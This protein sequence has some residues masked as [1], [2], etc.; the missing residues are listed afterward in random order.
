MAATV[1]RAAAAPHSLAASGWSLAVR[2]LRFWLTNYRRTWRGSIYSS[3]LN[4]LL[5]LGAM[6]LGL[7]SL[8]DAHGTAPLGRVTYLAFLAPGLLAAAAMETAVGE[9]TYPVYGSVKWNKTYQAAVASP[10]RPE[11]IF[12]GHVLFVTL[13]LAMN[14]A[15]FLAV[16]AAF[17]AVRSPWMI[18][19]LPV[20][21]LTGLAFATPIEAWA[22]TRTKDSSF[23]MIFRF[24][25]IPLF[26]FSGTFFP[27]TQLP[28]WLQPVAYLTPLWHGVSLCRALN[29]GTADLGQALVDVAYLIALA[30]VGLLAGNR[31]YRRRLHV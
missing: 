29:L 28:E 2:Q 25:M 1:T 26:L 31:S 6:G 20:A 9:A 19:A 7:G 14:S 12:H 8:V 17:G 22:V 15:I 18:A 11:D 5:F 3:V 16:A 27:I 21:V 13:R 23:A 4:P 24:G 10:L 30:T